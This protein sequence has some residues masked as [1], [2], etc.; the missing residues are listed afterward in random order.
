MYTKVF[1]LEFRGLEKVSTMRKIVYGF[2]LLCFRMPR[3]S[4][5]LFLPLLSAD[6]VAGTL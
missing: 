5:R 6:F 4:R 3:R 1:A 2:L